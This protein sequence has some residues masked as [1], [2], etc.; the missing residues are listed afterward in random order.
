[1]ELVA[2]FHKQNLFC[3]TFFI[4]VLFVPGPAVK[5]KTIEDS[6]TRP[7]LPHPASHLFPAKVHF[8]GLVFKKRN[9]TFVPVDPISRSST[10]WSWKQNLT[11][12]LYMYTLISY[13]IPLT[14]VFANIYF[15]CSV[16]SN[17][18][19]KTGT[20][21]WPRMIWPNFAA[22]FIVCPF[23][24]K[25]CPGIFKLSAFSWAQSGWPCTG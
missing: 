24:T 5:M 18:K 6:L 9:T 10:F 17:V 4:S 20:N 15:K 8:K 12:K 2:L 13:V 25:F 11:Y 16:C 21:S 19:A 1:M 23:W 22:P 14:W 3:L 7:V